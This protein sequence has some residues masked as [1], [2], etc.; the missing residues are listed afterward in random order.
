ML[1]TAISAIGLNE[2]F[3]IL[4][5]GGIIL[6][7]ILV[8]ILFWSSGSL[9]NILNGVDKKTYEQSAYDGISEL[10]RIARLYPSK[11][12]GIQASKFLENWDNEIEPSLERLDRDKKRKKLRMLYQ[13]NIHPILKAYEQITNLLK[14]V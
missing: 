7:C 14:G 13:S 12:I 5:V 10:R 8:A 11:K 2:L 1:G 9:G 3:P 6:V 4:I